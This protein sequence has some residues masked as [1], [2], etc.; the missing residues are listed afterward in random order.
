M[1]LFIISLIFLP[2]FSFS[3]VHTSETFMNLKDGA[4][5]VRL[6]TKSKTINALKNKN[7]KLSQI[8]EDKQSE[9][10]DAI[11]SAFETSFNYCNTYYFYDYKSAE[12]KRKNFR[13]NLL[14][15]HLEPIDSIQNLRNNYLIAAFSRTEG[16]S[17]NVPAEVY[18]VQEN[19]ELKKTNDTSYV[20]YEGYQFDALVLYTPDLILVQSPYPHF[21]RE[22]I[23]IKK[24]SPNEVVMLLEKKLIKSEIKI[25]KLNNRYKNK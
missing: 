23:I 1:R 2:L 17:T 6:E 5:L 9:R 3:Q 20:F 21:V 15:K 8:I 19:G 4:L 12:I 18:E 14:N 22:H 16:D 24:R 10:N 13:G 7:P 11:I 25:S